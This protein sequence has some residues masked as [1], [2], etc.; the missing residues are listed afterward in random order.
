MDYTLKTEYK[1]RFEEVR[2]GEV[3]ARNSYKIPMMKT[4]PIDEK[5]YKA[6][7]VDFCGFHYNINNEEYVRIVEGEFKE[8]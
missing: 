5:D 7:A 4:F 2:V 8:R 3:F 1:T 6:N